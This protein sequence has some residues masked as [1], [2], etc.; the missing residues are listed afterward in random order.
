VVIGRSPVLGISAGA[1]HVRAVLWWRD[2]IRWAGAA[3]YQGLDALA[4]AIARLAGEAGTPVRRARVVLERDV[5]Q[6]RSI[7]PAPPLKPEA[8]RRY[9]ALEAP[10]LFRKNGAPLVTDGM[11]VALTKTDA[12]LWAGAVA[13]PLVQATLAGCVQAGLTVEALGPAADVLP[14]ALQA[15]EGSIAFP[16][17]WTT[18]VLDVGIGGVWR[19]RMVKNAASGREMPNPEFTRAL[20]GLGQEAPHFAAAYATAIAQPRLSLLPADARAAEERHS[21]RRMIKVVAIGAALWLLA[22]GTYVG[23]LAWL[24]HTATQALGNSA[25]AVDSAIILRRQLGLAR[26]TLATAADAE[27]RRSRHVALLAAVTQ[28]LG[29]STYLVA[30]QVTPDG[31]V[32]LAGYAPV[33][34]RVVAAL[35][36][37]APLRDVRLEGPVTREAGSGMRDARDRFAIVASLEVRP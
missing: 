34:A 7:V 8:L 11:R 25:P 37:T 1:T 18:E 17:G 5:V 6:L 19:S 16:N 3:P 33:A 23:R 24:G 21:R 13:E 20:A 15:T 32:R 14:R 29:D 27:S 10:R 4:E 30:L 2:A 12:A 31:V 35:E 36:R 22:A 28:A 26:A 9:V